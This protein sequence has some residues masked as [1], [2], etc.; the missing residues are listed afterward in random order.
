MPTSAGRLSRST[1]VERAAESEVGQRDAVSVPLERRGDVLHAER[2]D[3]EE[4]TEAESLVAWNRTKKQDV[5]E[6]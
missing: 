3:A 2:L 4:R 6:D 1:R 5:H